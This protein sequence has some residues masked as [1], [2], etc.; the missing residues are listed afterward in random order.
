MGHRQVAKPQELARM[1][2]RLET[3]GTME[4][5]HYSHFYAPSVLG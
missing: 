1:K 4:N 3:L 2:R 5:D